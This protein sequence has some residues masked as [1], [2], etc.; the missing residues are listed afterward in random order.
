MLQSCVVDFVESAPAVQAGEHT[1]H[2]NFLP[3]VSYPLPPALAMPPFVPQGEPF[4]STTNARMTTDHE[5]SVKVCRSE[6]YQFHW[7][8]TSFLIC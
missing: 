8:H 7:G 4:P 1:S 3:S 2:V 5:Q 6:E